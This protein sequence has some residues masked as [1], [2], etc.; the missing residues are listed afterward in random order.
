[1][2]HIIVFNGLL[3]ASIA[4]AMLKG[5]APERL[6]ATI[7][8]IAATASYLA[9]YSGYHV[10]EADILLIDAI[11]LLALIAVAL[12]ANRYWPMYEAALQLLTVAIHAVKAYNPELAYWMYG[13]A[14][15]KIAYPTL[16]ILV[17]GV[18]RHRKRL[19]GTGVDRPWSHSPAVSSPR[20]HDK[21][22][23]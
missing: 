3:I 15:A 17:I 20:F 13:G 8:L 5:G 2:T 21:L 6:I 10:L 14:S 22:G 12:V 7:F 4:Y 16:I 18:A 23:E 11:A 19:I 9:P 1:M